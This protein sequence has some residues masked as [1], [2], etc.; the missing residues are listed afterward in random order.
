M[1]GFECKEAFNDRHETKKVKCVR[2]ILDCKECRF[3]A[4]LVQGLALVVIIFRAC[5]QNSIHFDF[6]SSAALW[7][8][9]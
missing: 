7:S 9:S 5:E 8:V 6:V 1:K 3:R 4:L 2:A